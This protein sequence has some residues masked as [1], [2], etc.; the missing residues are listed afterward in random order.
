MTGAQLSILFNQ[1]SSAPW[2]KVD[3]NPAI[4]EAQRFFCFGAE[5]SQAQKWSAAFQTA[6]RGNQPRFLVCCMGF[7]PEA[8]SASHRKL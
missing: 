8:A 2:T 1:V 7:N 6:Q 4:G 5:L 3:F